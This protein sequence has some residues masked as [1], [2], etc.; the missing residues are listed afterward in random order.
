MVLCFTVWPW[1]ASYRSQFML[2][3]VL[4]TVMLVH[5]YV[6]GLDWKCLFYWSSLCIWTFP[7]LER[8]SDFLFSSRAL[9]QYDTSGSSGNSSPCWS[10][11][12][13]STRGH[14]P[15][16]DATRGCRGAE[17]LPGMPYCWQSYWW[18]LT[19]A[20][21][22]ED[23]ETKFFKPASLVLN[24]CHW[25]ETSSKQVLRPIRWIIM[26]N[27]QHCY[28]MMNRTCHVEVEFDLEDINP[29]P[30]T[31]LSSSQLTHVWLLQRDVGTKTRL[32]V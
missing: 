17:E 30:L 25:V 29:Q 12:E 31:L 10:L 22:K 23:K 15:S 14:R 21:G 28:W 13:N 27:H 19:F 26:Q 9:G 20:S 32:S 18:S 5:L 2:H 4:S 3:A 11:G 8:T 16:S 7:P 1:F 6:L 24:V